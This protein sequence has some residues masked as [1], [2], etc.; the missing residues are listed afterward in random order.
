MG[1]NGLSQASIS[2]RSRG[3]VPEKGQQAWRLVCENMPRDATDD[4]APGI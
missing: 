4:S 1:P 2:L 3:W